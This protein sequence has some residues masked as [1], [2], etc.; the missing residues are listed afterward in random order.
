MIAQCALRLD[1][2]TQI[3]EEAAEFDDLVQANYVDSYHNLTL[4]H[5]S[6]FQW[7]YLQC[8]PSPERAMQRMPQH[9]LKADDD[10]VLNLESAIRVA[11]ANP[12]AGPMLVKLI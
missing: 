10:V 3:E 8:R 2:Q 4:K 12:D 11:D 1:F 9:I 5:Y 7:I 6:L